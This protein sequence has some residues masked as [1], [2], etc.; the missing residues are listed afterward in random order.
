MEASNVVLYT[1]AIVAIRPRDDGDGRKAIEAAFAGHSSLK[2]VWVVNDDIDIRDRDM[3][4]WA[5]ATR[6]QGD[7]DTV[8]FQSKGSSLDPSALAE[9]RQPGGPTGS[10]NHAPA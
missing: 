1:H 3:V 5:F 6:F 2:H 4:E 7:R 10:P 9:T 8:T